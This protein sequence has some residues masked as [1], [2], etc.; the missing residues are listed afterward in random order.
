M[1]IGTR[2]KELRIERKLTQKELADI[3]TVSDRTV[4]KWEQLKGNP[5]VEMLPKLAET[6]G[7]SCDYILNGKESSF[8]TNNAQ[9]LC[10]FISVRIEPHHLRQNDIPIIESLYQQHEFNFLC[11]CFLIALGQVASKSV[12]DD[13]FVETLMTQ[14]RKILFVK[15]RPILVQKMSELYFKY[16]SQE[17]E[18][19]LSKESFTKLLILTIPCCQL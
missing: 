12:E 3:L 8:R 2:I 13:A 4:S 9:S 7:V 16:K 5:D 11:S 10:D 18:S 14:F 15:S 19:Y 17:F 1:N 6:L